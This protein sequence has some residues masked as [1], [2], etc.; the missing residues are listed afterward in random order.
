MKTWQIIIIIVVILACGF[1]RE[2][3][4]SRRRTQRLN[5]AKQYLNKFTEWMNSRNRDYEIYNWLIE[6]S[7]IMQSMLGRIGI[8]TFRAPFG[9][10][11]TNNYPVI[12]N[13]IPEILKESQDYLGTD[14]GSYAQMVDGCL[15][16]FI[17]VTKETLKGKSKRLINPVALLSGGVGLILGIPFYVLSECK[18][19]SSQNSSKI[20]HS[21]IFSIFSGL[22]TLA[23][24]IVSVMGILIGWDV[25]ITKLAEILK[26]GVK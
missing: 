17:G 10:Y 19:I 14:V 2:L 21:R 12:L 15:R 13:A 1:I 3:F 26:V 23:T 4:A 24:L 5:F 8:I 22:A 6:K 18:V 16:R 9:M 11:T 20:V 25:F 7:E